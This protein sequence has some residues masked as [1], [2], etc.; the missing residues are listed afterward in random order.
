[1]G[2]WKEMFELDKESWDNL[3]NMA[4]SVIVTQENIGDGVTESNGVVAAAEGLVDMITVAKESGQ[5]SII[6]SQEEIMFLN[7]IFGEV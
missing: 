2:A 3:L 6:V 5:E 4:E 7:N 1:M